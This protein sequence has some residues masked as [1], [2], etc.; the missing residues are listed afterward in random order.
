MKLAERIFNII[1][2]RGNTAY[3]WH[4][5]IPNDEILQKE[6]HRLGTIDLIEKEIQPMAE[7]LTRSVELFDKALPK[8]NWG[9]SFLDAEAITLLN[10]VPVQARVALQGQL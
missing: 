1:Q 9:A 5:N 7:A 3:L 10:E 8:F 2:E 4:D 6:R